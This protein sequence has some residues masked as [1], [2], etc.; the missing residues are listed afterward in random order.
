MIQDPQNNDQLIDAN[1]PDRIILMRE[2]NKHPGGS[3]S[4]GARLFHVQGLF[5]A[6]F[7]D[8]YNEYVP[9]SDSQ[10]SYDTLSINQLRFYFTW[11]ASIR[12][13][14]AIEAGIYYIYLYFFELLNNIGVSDG[15]QAL[16][17]M[18]YIINTYKNSFAGSVHL[19]KTWFR[20]Y[21]ALNKIDKPFSRLVQQMGLTEL[22]PVES[23]EIEFEYAYALRMGGADFPNNQSIADF[24][25]YKFIKCYNTVIS[26]LIQLFKMYGID[27]EDLFKGT[28]N[29]DNSWFPYEHAVF[30]NADATKDRVVRLSAYEQYICVRGVWNRR[31]MSYDPISVSVVNLIIEKIQNALCIKAA[32]LDKVPPCLWNTPYMALINDRYFDE[33]IISSV[34][35]C[36]MPASSEDLPTTTYEIFEQSD[37]GVVN[38][39]WQA[40]SIPSTSRTDMETARQFVSQAHILADCMD[41]YDANTQ[42]PDTANVKCTYSMLSIPQTR[43]YITW[44]TK[45]KNNG[46]T[47][48]E[49][50]FAFI[51]ASEL[52]NKINA[53]SDL[54]VLEKL[55]P[56]IKHVPEISEIFFDY[57]V[58]QNVSVPFT[59]II[60]QFNV[61]TYFPYIAIQNRAYED[62]FVLFQD[63]LGF[64][65]QIETAGAFNLCIKKL[66]EYFENAGLTF[67]ILF[68]GMDNDRR[69]HWSAFSRAVYLF[70]N[71]AYKSNINV[72]VSDYDTYSYSTAYRRWTC[73]SASAINTKSYYLIGYIIKRLASLMSRQKLPDLNTK[74]VKSMFPPSPAYMKYI[75][76]IVSEDF[77]KIIDSSHNEYTQT[78]SEPVKVRVDV[79]LL[80]NVRKA[81]DENLEKLLADYEDDISEDTE[82]TQSIIT[83]TGWDA[84]FSALSDVQRRAVI[85]VLEERPNELCDLARAESVLPEVLI[86]SINT[87]AL[88]FTGD[89]IIEN[90]DEGSKIFE[91]YAEALK[92]VFVCYG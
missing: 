61:S 41:N 75:D 53:N 66:R 25:F 58:T 30:H 57:Y 70:D 16:E 28:Y 7:E 43:L 45:F 24:G 55:A 48:T 78:M 29:S 62:W 6:D 85:D 64:K 27:I 89:Y 14:Q 26:N 21:Y 47:H 13:R 59:D 15:I 46:Q 9:L 88:D 80:D 63:K 49:P 86:E 83:E 22:F 81:A 44:R 32:V 3:F 77:T 38:A 12:K 74:R 71:N 69:S 10:P 68:L 54:E 87:T 56:L 50:V 82:V 79:S 72:S 52:I 17:Q 34:K 76:A 23:Y 2:L 35:Q 37:S 73:L 20:D 51:Y 18:A 36:L 4:N 5:M 92:G 8:H 84:F 19:F 91:E 31:V 67:M 33:I 60:R 65:P 11:R 39:I 40:R 42:L 90:T 1:V